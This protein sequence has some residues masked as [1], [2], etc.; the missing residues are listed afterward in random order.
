MDMIDLAIVGATGIVGETI[1]SLL[2][3]STL[4]IRKIFPLSSKNSIG[5][6]IIFKNKEIYVESLEAFD[7]T[8]VKLVLFA[9]NNDIAKKYAPKA[10]KSGCWVIDN[11]S[12]FRNDDNIPLIVPEINGNIVSTLR[13]PCI[14]ANPN[15]S[16]IQMCMALKPIYD[17]AG[18]SRV[19]VATYQSV[20]GTGKKAIIELA[21]QTGDLLNGRPIKAT[22]YSKQ[23]AFNVLPHIDVFLDNGY[24]KEEMK[25]SWETKKIFNDDDIKINATAV[26]IPTFFGHSEAINIET[27]EHISILDVERA[28]KKF[29]GIKIIKGKEPYPTPMLDSVGNN[30][31]FVGRIRKDI[32]HPNGINLWVVTDNVR[33][34][35]AWNALQIAELTAKLF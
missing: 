10:V 13:T 28:L 26:R 4:A 7:F 12:E 25:M 35:A 31:V 16:T 21:K 1:L 22:I 2:E 29:S 8:Q 30:N 3:H 32:T 11:S 20:S 9:A 17:K 19:N 5:K 14:I 6:A 15:C 33:K 23:I 24:T 34:G 27:R 18:I